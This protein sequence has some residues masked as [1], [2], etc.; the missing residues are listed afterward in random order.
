MAVSSMKT[1]R[2]GSSLG[3]CFC[4]AIRAAATSGRSC[5]VARRL[6]FKRQLQMMQEAGDRRF[7]DRYLLRQLCHKFRQRDVRLLCDQLPDHSFVY[8]QDKFLV[9]AKLRRA[10]TARLAIKPYKTPHRAEA[11]TILVRN[12]RSGGP[13]FNRRHHTGAQVFRVW[14]RH[15]MLASPSRK[16]ES[17]SRL[18]ENT[19]DSIFTGNALIQWFSTLRLRLDDE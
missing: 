15:S 3:C 11:Y 1:S 4:R 10:D 5:S 13:S 9:A 2:F 12:F 6:F 14:L 7:A 19:P 18:P 16:L 8:G 17:Y